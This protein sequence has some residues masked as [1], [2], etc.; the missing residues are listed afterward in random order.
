MS[1]EPIGDHSRLLPGGFSQWLHDVRVA[2]RGTAP[3]EVPCGSCTAC[4]TSSQFIHI[5]PD[6]TQTRAHIPATLLFP[7]PRM[8]PGHVLMGYDKHGHCPMLVDQQCTIYAHR[9]RTCRTYDCRVFPASGV[10]LDPDEHKTLIAQQ[11]Q[12]WEF[13]YSSDRAHDQHAAVRAAAAFL[14][15]HA[16]EL[17]PDVAATPTQRAVIAVRVH[18]LFLA[19]TPSVDEVRSAI[20]AR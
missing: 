15:N 3:S 12:R 18:E 5:G 6:E 17:G 9:P 8:P 7:A 19:G 10:S 16:P 11:A 4:C 14:E 20:R 2:I 13:S 1:P